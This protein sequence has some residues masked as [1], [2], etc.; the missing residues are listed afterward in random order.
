MD[1][2]ELIERLRT[3]P[4]TTAI[5]I[6]AVSANPELASATAATHELPWAVDVPSF[7]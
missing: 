4:E 1:G 5:P 2:A 3:A 6:L 7:A